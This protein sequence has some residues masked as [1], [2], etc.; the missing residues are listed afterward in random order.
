MASAIASRL[1]G[2][3]EVTELERI[4]LP[5]KTL[6]HTL[7]FKNDMP[8]DLLK[9]RH[10]TGTQ[11]LLT[12][13]QAALKLVDTVVESQLLQRSQKR[14]EHLELLDDDQDEEQEE[15]EIEIQDMVSGFGH[16]EPTIESSIEILLQLEECISN[17]TSTSNKPKEPTFPSSL[18]VASSSL[19][20]SSTTS[21]S[22]YTLPAT[23][24]SP[25]IEEVMGQWSRLRGIVGDLGGSIRE[26]QR[27]RDG[28]QSVN[29]IAEQTYQ[30]TQLLEKCLK[31]IA[32][33]KQNCRHAFEKGLTNLEAKG[34]LDGNDMLELD[35]M[36]G[37]LSLQIESLQ[38][39]FPE[40]VSAKNSKSHP[41]SS[42]AQLEEEHGGL[43]HKKA[44]MA[45]L[46]R[47]LLVDWNS[48]RRRKEQLWRDLEECDRWRARIEKM[49]RQIESMLEPVEIFHK[50]CAN[51][52]GSLVEKN[53]SQQ[54]HLMVVNE[55][56]QEVQ[57]PKPESLSSW[58]SIPIE[59]PSQAD[60][61]MLASTLQELEEKQNMV[62]PAIE[63][64]FWVQEGEIQ[65]RTKHVVHSPSTPSTAVP[66]SLPRSPMDVFAGSP[67]DF[68]SPL[69][70]N[71]PMLE[72][73]HGLKA[74]WSNLKASL[75]TASTQLQQHHA[76]MTERANAFLA[77]KKRQ[78]EEA[79]AAAAARAE[80]E[81]ARISTEVSEPS[82]PT[83]RRSFTNSSQRSSS[84]V[85][86]SSNSSTRILRGTLVPSIS[87]DSPTVKKYMLLKGEKPASSKPRPWCPSI[88]PQS[89]GLPG[90]P[91]QTSS[92]GYFLIST[93]QSMDSFGSVI[94]T[95]AP[96]PVAPPPAPTPPPP[97]FNRPPF[98][99]AGPRLYTKPTPPPTRPAPQRSASVAGGDYSRNRCMS[100]TISWE[101]KMVRRSN[102]MAF[103]DK[104]PKGSNQ[105]T[106][107]G[108]ISQSKSGRK[109][110]FSS[111]K[112]GSSSAA[113]AGR[114]SS[115]ASECNTWYGNHHRH[116]IDNSSS[117]D[118]TVTGEFHTNNRMSRG[119][120]NFNKQGLRTRTKQNDSSSSLDSMMS[121]SGYSYGGRGYSS[122]SSHGELRS[123][124]PPLPLPYPSAFGSSFTAARST[125]ALHTALLSSMSSHS[126]SSFRNSALS[127]S[128]S[129][130]T[131]SRQ[132]E[133][134]GA[135]SSK[136]SSGSSLL[137]RRQVYHQDSK[138]SSWM[139]SGSLISALSFR[140]PTY[141]FEEDF[142]SF[143]ATAH[144]GAV[145]N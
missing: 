18:S 34:G 125:A 90:F 92:W 84:V 58:P 39:S 118:E 142:G 37:L 25:E 131:D 94:A 139:G 45:T 72:R 10:Q 27:I 54:H 11:Q 137:S 4:P 99:P 143:E 43:A 123:P 66:S 9:E 115:N 127:F 35:S 97:K 1:D 23:H 51:L 145:V 8:V 21:L 81:K 62:V 17:R 87:M 117:E 73:Q 59:E 44:I 114:R 126:S 119:Y 33:D 83:L 124:S 101:N 106:R 128:S 19:S 60:L 136:H 47:E 65:H 133:H 108:N 70:P 132:S 113:H 135:L 12:W 112:D 64:M 121:S 50:M 42:Q 86:P 79:A 105:N 103:D 29:N 26:H 31:A 122:L 129:Q 95:P 63:N 24:L 88:N 71:L 67:L 78:A 111:A 80:E 120:K 77:M 82:T 14:N 56:D 5:Y 22:G 52:L 55:E 57:S 53:G 93:S 16:Y 15:L 30:A 13:I 46:F 75:D 140:V 116:S 48:L 28:I 3:S 85:S 91:V 41:Y 49:A 141:S 134:D 110:S 109:G 76:T 36:V 89:P 130:R 69:Y 144:E 107:Q 61:E 32:Q 100:P 96:V 7:V 102:S 40:C 2:L 138:P 20:L 68:S 74:R 38:T 98:S 104:S 6:Y